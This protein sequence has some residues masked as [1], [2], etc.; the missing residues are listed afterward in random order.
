MRGLD[1]E[2]LYQMTIVAAVKTRD[3]LVLGT[4]SVTTVV[5]PGQDGQVNYMKSYSNVTKLF[6][7]D[8]CPLGLATWGIGNIGPRSMTGLITDF[9]DTLNG[10]PKTMEDAAKS[11]AT[12]ISVLYNQA[13]QSVE[14]S[15]RPILGFFVGGYSNKQPLA[16]LWEVRFPGANVNIVR[17]QGDFGANW[18]GIELPFTRLHKGFD[19]RIGDKLAAAGVPQQTI[20]SALQGFESPVVFDSMPNQVAVEFCRYVLRTTIDFAAFEVGVPSCGEPLQTCILNRKEGFI[21][22]DELKLHS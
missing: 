8:D 6:P 9:E 18:R 17:G 1:I 15:K 13:F 22:V 19:P 14:E 11:L 2:W 21:W 4:D 5:G 7:L 3:T 12:F 16:E 20:Q 10:C